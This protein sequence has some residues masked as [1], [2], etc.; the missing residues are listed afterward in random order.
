M[1]RWYT[2]GRASTPHRTPP[3]LSAVDGNPLGSPLEP[4]DHLLGLGALPPD[5]VLECERAMAQDPTDR[6]ASAATSAALL[7]ERLDGARL[8]EQALEVGIR[9][10]VGL[11]Y[12]S[13]AGIQ[14]RTTPSTC[15][16]QPMEGCPGSSTM[17]STRTGPQSQ[18]SR[19]IGP[20]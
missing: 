5:L 13:S 17:F 7:V 11:D 14:A 16:F 12:R 6:F 10:R 3:G 1:P 8:R 9:D 20:W 19:V 18:S 2:R 15:S 4:L